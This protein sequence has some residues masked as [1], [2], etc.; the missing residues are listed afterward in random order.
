MRTSSTASVMWIVPSLTVLLLLEAGLLAKT[1]P[2]P[3]WDGKDHSEILKDLVL[4]YED[5]TRD[6]RANTE[7]SGNASY[8]GQCNLDCQCVDGKWKCCRLRKSVKNLSQ[9]ERDRFT[10][11]FLTATRNEIYQPAMRSIQWSHAVF[12]CGKVPKSLYTQS[13]TIGYHNLLL[14]AMENLLRLIDCRVTIPYWDVSLDYGKTYLE[15]V[16]EGFG[17]TGVPPDYCVV[18][19]PYRKGEYTILKFSYNG[20]ELPYTSC[21]TRNMSSTMKPTSYLEFNTMLTVP[22]D[23]SMMFEL[24]VYET[25][26]TNFHLGFGGTFQGVIPGMDPLFYMIHNFGTKV[27]ANYQQQGPDH[28]TGGGRWN[29]S[30]P[31][32]T[33]PW[34]QNREFFDAQ[35]FPN[36]VCI[37]WDAVADREKLIEM[38]HYAGLETPRLD[39][40]ALPY[41]ELRNKDLDTNARADFLLFLG[42]LKERFTSAFKYDDDGLHLTKDWLKIFMME[43]GFAVKNTLSERA[44]AQYSS[45]DPGFL[46]TTYVPSAAELVP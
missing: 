7:C 39:H 33:L 10:R 2:A 23:S 45:L 6:P 27:L 12:V 40:I 19:G 29:N 31:V 28:F 21:L 22:P 11:T 15:Q 18:D 44:C 46:N 3:N 30:A 32:E 8:T 14:F 4:N 5:H 9:E 13:D 1:I 16:P 36:D 25:F 26:D 24:G 41:K 38:G 17:G 43:S 34:F 42:R 20:V 35:N 37:R